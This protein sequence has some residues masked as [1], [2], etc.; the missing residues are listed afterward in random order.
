MLMRI[1]LLTL[2][3]VVPTVAATANDWAEFRG[4]KRDGVCTETSLLKEW[5]AAGPAQLWS[6][7]NLG[8]GF[9]TPTIADGMIFGMGTRDG[10]DGIWAL[11]QTDGSELWFTPID[12]PRETNQ[13]NGPSGSPT[14]DDGKLYTVSSKGQFVCLNAADGKEIWKIDYLEQYGS[15]VP[16]WGFTDSPLIDG[17]HVIAIPASEKAAVVALNKATGKEVWK[18]VIPGGVGGGAGYS[19]AIKAT[20]AGTPQYVI[21]TG[22][23]A[24][25]IGV[26]AASG[27]LLWQ[28]KARPAAGGVA[29]IPI[30][31][32]TEDRVWVSCSYAGG[33]ALL[34][35]V[36]E[37][38][39]FKANE[40]KLYRK[41]ELNNHH[42]GMVQVGDYAYFGHN[43][44]DG[45]PVC[46]NLKTGA[47]QWGPEQNP[48]GCD[49]SA[50]VLYADNRLYY[51]YQN[52]MLVLMEPSPEK[53]KVISSFK[54]PEP[55]GKEHWAHPVIADG[56]LYIRDQEKLH[57]FDVKAK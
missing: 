51:R 33:S 2:M 24:G 45:N 40:L 31:I 41:R 10:K 37:G 6:A 29:Q 23:S 14:Y 43:Q 54:L 1:F 20:I 39:K 8:I 12:T 42:G 21:L 47:I 18:T 44:N 16:T 50:A 4:P 9:S 26:D 22:E 13:N 46:V 49:G 27:K 30:P 28:Y 15:S 32:V 36:K 7:Q 25:V 17:A 35:I 19:S 3:L 52:G 55:S 34:Q 57:C 38:G 5:P 48:E 11:K 53:L 56:R